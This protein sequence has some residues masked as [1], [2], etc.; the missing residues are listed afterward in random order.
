[1]CVIHYF[2]CISLLFC[3]YW[4][5][6]NVK[7]RSSLFASYMTFDTFWKQK[8]SI[9]FKDLFTFFFHTSKYLQCTVMN[10]NVFQW[11]V[12]YLY[13]FSSLFPS[14]PSTPPPPPKI[15]SHWQLSSAPGEPPSSPW[16]SCRACRGTSAVSSSSSAAGW[17]CPVG[18]APGRRHP[19]PDGSCFVWSAGGPDSPQAGRSCSHCTAVASSRW[20][21]SRR[22]SWW[23]IFD[24]SCTSPSLWRRT[25]CS[26]PRAPRL[27]IQR[28]AGKT[29]ITSRSEW[30]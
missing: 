9:N 7:W 26:R 21:V 1:M 5:L 23:G 14:K 10:M 2:C 13:R 8:K 6:I 25:R 18:G 27:R 19:R 16:L 11:N 4:N 22:R 24:P 15:T 20:S 28:P 30:A 12:H 17:S 3:S 29:G